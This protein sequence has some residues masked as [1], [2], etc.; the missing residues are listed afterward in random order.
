MEIGKS[1]AKQT[2]RVIINT[3]S[4]AAMKNSVDILRKPSFDKKYF[5]TGHDAGGW[6]VNGKLQSPDEA[7]DYIKYAPPFSIISDPTDTGTG[8]SGVEKR[9]IAVRVGQWTRVT[10]DTENRL[11][12]EG[13]T[14][15]GWT[16]KF[17]GP[18]DSNFSDEEQKDEWLAQRLDDGTEK[19]YMIIYNKVDNDLDSRGIDVA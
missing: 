10:D 16:Q 1:I 7:L 19:E 14:G 8:A 5:N 4:H 12:L 9:S 2:N 18:Y 15:E 6:W 13:A 17:F 3:Q 11:T